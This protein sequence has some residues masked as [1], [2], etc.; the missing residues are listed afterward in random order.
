MNLSIIIKSNQ[1]AKV[2]GLWVFE[3]TQKQREQ[4][5]AWQIAVKKGKKIETNILRCSKCIEKNLEN[6][7]TGVKFRAEDL[8][9]TYCRYFWTNLSMFW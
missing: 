6:E 5:F 4:I 1:F 7:T 3:E 9:G 8:H 2:Q